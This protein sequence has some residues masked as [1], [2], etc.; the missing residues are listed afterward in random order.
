MPV[1]TAQKGESRLQNTAVGLCDRSGLTNC[2]IY[3]KN[4]SVRTVVCPV[5]NIK[6]VLLWRHAISISYVVTVDDER[7][8]ASRH[9]SVNVASRGSLSLITVGPTC[10]PRWVILRGNRLWNWSQLF[11]SWPVRQFIASKKQT[12]ERSRYGSWLSTTQWYNA[13]HVGWVIESHP[14]C[15]CHKTERGVRCSGRVE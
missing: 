5:A 3:Q 10:Q 14:S 2:G 1:L 12:V 6:P 7:A 8:E 13:I 15:R 9:D 4:L 11:W